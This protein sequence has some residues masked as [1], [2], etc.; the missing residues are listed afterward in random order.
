MSSFPVLR[1][2]TILPE[3][4]YAVLGI[5]RA[6]DGRLHVTKAG[7][8]PARDQHREDLIADGVCRFEADGLVV[9]T[10][11]PPTSR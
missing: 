5:A 9:I 8:E 11:D 7:R 4:G 2:E 10:I 6:F 3:R 1:M